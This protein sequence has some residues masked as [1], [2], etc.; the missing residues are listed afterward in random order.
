MQSLLDDI[1]S[2]LRVAWRCD[3]LVHRA[4]PVVSVHDNYDALGYPPDG[5]ARDARYTRYVSPTTLLRT[6]T[7]AMVPPLLRALAA[8]PPRDLLLVCPGLV[9]RRDC[10]D[11]LHTGAPHQV[12]LW[13]LTGPDSALSL[14][15]LTSLVAAAALPGREARTT[16]AVHPY[17]V[18]GLQLDV[19][20]GD[21]WVEIGECGAAH[22]A[23]L[24]RCGLQHARGLAMGLGL[25][26]ILML[27]KGIPD[28]RILRSEEPRVAAQLLDLSPWRPVSRMP[29]VTRDL[30]LAVDAG[31]D[32]SPEALG[33]RVREALGPRA[34]LVEH[35]AAVTSTPAHALSPVA[36][37]R[38]GI[39]D[40]QNNVLLRVVL[41][42]VDRTLTTEEC[43]VLRDEIYAALHQ[44]TR[45]SWATRK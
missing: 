1:V 42:A 3:V 37:E 19:R 45:W 40:G 24:A 38:L 7:S 10:I 33:D 12:D 17:T 25:D 2:A 14:E 43:N 22:P 35:V 32:L 44:G 15:Q 6:Q 39:G 9:Y 26:R 5:A 4:N 41:R 30:S 31:V 21:E 11:R 16:P 20:D 36:A 8:A 34:D 28:I 23:L 27:R 13:R 18:D 29:P